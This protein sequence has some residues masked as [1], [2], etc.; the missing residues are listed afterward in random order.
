MVYVFRYKKKKQKKWCHSV[1]LFRRSFAWESEK[2]KTCLKVHRPQP[3]A[4]KK[5]PLEVYII[6]NVVVF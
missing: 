5:C 4:Q 2:N 3:V 6:L 1:F